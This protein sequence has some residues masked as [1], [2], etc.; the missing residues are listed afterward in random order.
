M[1]LCVTDD[2]LARVSN[3]HAR[4]FKEDLGE[5]KQHVRRLRWCKHEAC[6]GCAGGWDVL[7]FLIHNCS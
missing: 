3:V 7:V 6:G 4:V 1:L 2:D 5:R